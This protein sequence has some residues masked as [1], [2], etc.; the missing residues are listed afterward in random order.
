MTLG[1]QLGVGAGYTALTDDTWNAAA[2]DAC[3]RN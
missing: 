1:K 2:T 3:A